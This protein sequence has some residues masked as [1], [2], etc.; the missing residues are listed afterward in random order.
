VVNTGVLERISR[1]V[2]EIKLELKG[3]REK[4]GPLHS[5]PF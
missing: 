5:K 2:E 1:E 4:S 3:I